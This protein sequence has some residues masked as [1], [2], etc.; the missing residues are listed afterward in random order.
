MRLQMAQKNKKELKKIKL[1][2]LKE[3][4]TLPGDHEEKKR[5]KPGGAQPRPLLAVRGYCKFLVNVKGTG[6]QPNSQ[7]LGQP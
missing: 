5:N 2:I 4:E 3:I 7:K 6:L 1:Q